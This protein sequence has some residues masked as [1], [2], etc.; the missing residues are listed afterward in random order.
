MTEPT[1]LRVRYEWQEGSLPPPYHYEYTITIGP[2]LTGSLEFRPDY[3]LNAPPV[4]HVSLQLTERDLAQISRLLSAGETPAR[5]EPPDEQLSVGGA[6][7]WLEGSRGGRA[8]HVSLQGKAK[9]AAATRD[10]IL[11]I[12]SLVPDSVWN[13]MADKQ[14]E[15]QRDYLARQGETS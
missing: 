2:G 9:D 14:K 11:A 8:F 12:R 6:V 7:E 15:Y 4:W 1:D 10:V 13:Q 5:Q 3:A